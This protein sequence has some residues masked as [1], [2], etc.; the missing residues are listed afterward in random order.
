MTVDYADGTESAVLTG[1]RSAADVRAGS[2][3]LA[4]LV[5]SW[6][7][8]YHFSPARLGLLAPLR[9][10]PDRSVVDLGCGSGVLTRV[11][12][13]S[14]AD[15]LGI[16]GAA[17]RAAAARERCRDLPNVS[18]RTGNIVAELAGR[19][20][21]DLALMCGVLEYSAQFA[22]GPAGVLAAVTE[23][24]AN[25]GVLVLAIENQLGLKYL[26]GGAE[27]HLGTA[28]VGLADYP[29]GTPGPRT[30]TRQTL[31][32]LLTGAGLGA[33]RWL[34]PYPDYK[35]PRLVLDESVFTRPDADELVEKLVRDPLAGTFAGNDA[36]VSGRI[37]QRLAMAEGLGATT[38][39]SFLVLAARTPDA[40]ARA[41]DPGLG[42]LISGGRLPGWRRVRRLTEDTTLHTVHSGPGEVSSWLRQQHLAT[43]P[44]RAGR[45]LDALLLDALRTADLAETRRLLDVW[46]TT[47]TAHA[48]P[49][50]AD[51]ARHPFLPHHAGVPVLPP[52]HLDIHPGNLIVD[53][54]GSVTRVDLE[55]LA[56][57]GVD[58]ELAMLRALAELVRDIVHGH[59]P[60][61]WDPRATVREI[62]AELCALVGLADALARRWPELVAAEA[63]LQSAVSGRAAELVATEIANDAD[64]RPAQPLWQVPGGLTAVRDNLAGRRDAAAERELAD[65]LAR[66][67]AHIDDLTARLRLTEHGL[68]TARSELDAKDD[69]IGQAFADLAAAVDEAQTAWHANAAAE[70][71]QAA[72]AAAAGSLADRLARTR[73]A[74]DSL[75]GATLVRVAH[76]SLWP[77]A[78]LVRGVRDL[79]LARPGDEPDGL[80][81]RVGQRAPRLTAR[82]AGRYR[83]AAA[84]H[85]DQGLRF[86]L[87]VPDG[88]V[89][90]GA[91]QVVELTGWV[92][93]ASVGVHAVTVEAGTRRVPASRGH[94]QPDAAAAL[95][96]AGVRAPDG[97]GVTV[98][99]P[100]AATDA[101]TELPLTLHVELDDG[102]RLRRELPSLT[103][104]RTAST[105]PVRVR[106][107]ADGPKVAICL[108]SYRPDKD[109][110]AKQLDSLRAQKHPNWVCLVC[111][112]GSGPDTVE[113]I[114]ELTEDDERFVVVGNPDNVG[115]YR[116]FERAMAMVPADADAVALCDQDDVWDA[117]K[118]E[119]LLE[120]LVD[121]AVSLAYADMRLIDEH[122]ELVAPSFWRHRR[123]QCHDLDSLLLLNTITGAASLVRAEVV[124]S[125]VLPFP[126][127]T[128][129]AFHDQW[130]GAAA[131]AAGRVA[132]VDRPLHSYRQH[133]GAVSG[134][135]DNRL[136]ENLPT[137]TGWLPLA[138][139]SARG[140]GAELGAELEAVAEYELRRV[141]QFATVLLIRASHRLA[142]ATRDRISQLTRI[143]R[144]PVPLVTRALLAGPDR[145]E[146]AGAERYLLAAALRWKALRPRRLRL[147]ARQPIPL[148]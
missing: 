57:D 25:D 43:E 143:E 133:A 28:W 34:L 45:P 64:A 74:L 93:H 38:A 73:A 82:L 105:R 100:V 129:S 102:T 114:T 19:G 9:L 109:F 128:P 94:H 71:A 148:D 72:A 138:L 141:A 110:L 48:R 106:W 146:T 53:A 54:D 97:S 15:V 86:D 70:Q 83:R 104:V 22:N 77:A 50:G 52:D 35:M 88:P 145:A 17:D 136:D 92:A 139:G 142:T 90:V 131:L 13:E 8:A 39:P 58:A 87:P 111:D 126:P 61:P 113:M 89:P 84:V 103:L 55:W 4:A 116:N 24:L 120:Q 47:C 41:A 31:A 140:L 121:P 124:R 5:R 6:E 123:N 1:L 135:R 78:R 80:L 112:D 7:L 27:D 29:G 51:L 122:D 101:P 125:M 118:L 56:T 20:P 12:G 44:L 18:V 67:R 134:R 36:A 144:D 23:A 3:E 79:A 63:A 42:W 37:A 119:V 107:P 85:R 76:R 96:A 68:A 14:G 65:E 40:L 95:R 115:F 137:R 60:H 30:W 11:L 21:F 108:A 75:E 62:L 16:E 32:A 33:Q 147:P 98:R 46:R 91:G 81:R 130:I 10:A 117:D 69:R 66:Q 132:F 99:I 127:G 2:A 49:A 59:A 26:L